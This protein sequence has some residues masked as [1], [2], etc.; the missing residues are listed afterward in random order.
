MKKIYLLTF[1]IILFAGKEFCLAQTYLY[2]RV[3]IVRNGVKTNKNDDAHYITF[4]KKGCYESDKNGYKNGNS[5]LIEYI[6]DENNLHCFYGNCP[7]GMAN[8]YFSND[9][10]RLNVRLNDG[11]IF[12]YQ[13]ELS[14]N[15][16]ASRRSVRSNNNNST[17]INIVPPPVINNGGS[18]VGGGTSGSSSKPI[19]PYITCKICRGTGICTRCKGKCGEWMY[20]DTYTGDGTKA[21]INCPSCSGNGRCSNCR[22]TGRL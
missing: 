22:G 17:G 2:K 4:N 5:S 16:T 21:W 10:S 20:V 12:V 11:V 18:S 19:S 9:Y 1:L 15:T 13:R 7:S 6:K 8:Y 14:G 3:M